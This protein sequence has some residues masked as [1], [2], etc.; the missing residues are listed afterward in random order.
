MLGQAFLGEKFHN[1]VCQ[2]CPQLLRH[3]DHRSPD[4]GNITM[5][6]QLNGQ[7]PTV[8]TDLHADDPE[9]QSRDLNFDIDE[10]VQSLAV[11]GPGIC[12]H[13]GDTFGVGVVGHGL[14]RPCNQRKQRM[15]ALVP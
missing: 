10:G 12:N 14:A 13:E 2:R 9:G 11:Y 15:L 3:L 5:R 7:A 6:R 1:G 4:A 8:M